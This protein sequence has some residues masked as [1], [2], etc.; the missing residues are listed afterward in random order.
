MKSH[1]VLLLSAHIG[2]KPNSIVSSRLYN[3]LTI[4]KHQVVMDIADADYV[5]VNTCGFEISREQISVK[6]LSQPQYAENKLKVISVGCLNKINR[7]L[8]SKV[9]NVIIVDS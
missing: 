5:I 8:V 1:R 3:Y 2:C 4:N 6:L 7:D 9:S